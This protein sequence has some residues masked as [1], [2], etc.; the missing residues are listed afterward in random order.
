M[1]DKNINYVEKLI[2]A[3][4]SNLGIMSFYGFKEFY[5]LKDL[6]KDYNVLT[7]KSVEDKY[8]LDYQSQK[9]NLDIKELILHFNNYSA[10]KKM[11]F[12]IYETY[13]FSFYFASKINPLYEMLQYLEYYRNSVKLLKYSD[14]IT[15][16][17]FYQL[18]VKQFKKIRNSDD[19]GYVFYIDDNFDSLEGNLKS[20]IENLLNK[21]KFEKDVDVYNFLKE[22]S[23]LY[24]NANLSSIKKSESG[25][26]SITEKNE[27]KKI[28][29]EYKYINLSDDIKE[30][31]K[32][33]GIED[34]LN[35]DLTFLNKLQNKYT[36]F[37]DSINKDDSLCGLLKT[38]IYAASF[39]TK[40]S[41]NFYPNQRMQAITEVSPR[42]AIGDEHDQNKSFYGDSE[43]IKAFSAYY[44]FMNGKRNPL[45]EIIDNRL[46]NVMDDE[47]MKMHKYFYDNGIEKF[48]YDLIYDKTIAGNKSVYEL[49]GTVK[50][51]IEIIESPICVSTFQNGLLSQIK[52][53]VS[54][55]INTTAQS[56]EF[57]LTSV[58]RELFYV[59]FIPIGKIKIS[60]SDAYNYL[61]FFKMILE[62]SSDSNVEIE[63]VS[64]EQFVS[65][66]Y[67]LLGVREKD[68]EKI[69]F[70]S[71][72]YEMND[73]S[74]LNM[75]QDYLVKNKY[76]KPFTARNDL[77]LFYSLV[78]FG[79]YKQVYETGNIDFYY[80]FNYGDMPSIRKVLSNLNTKELFYVFSLYG[81]EFKDFDVDF[82]KYTSDETLNYN[83]KLRDITLAY[84]H[85]SLEFYK[86]YKNK[87]NG[88]TELNSFY[89]IFLQSK[90]KT[91]INEMVKI[92]NNV[93]IEN[94]R[95]ID[96]LVFKVNDI[97]DIDDFVM[98]ILPSLIELAH[99]F[100]INN[101]GLSHIIK[102]LDY[103]CY[104]ISDLLFRNMFIK[105]KFQLMELIKQFTD[106]MFE[107][108]DK[109]FNKTGDFVLK[110]DIGG[111]SVVKKLESI[112]DMLDNVTLASA[113]LQNCFRDP[114]FSLNDFYKNSIGDTDYDE[115]IINKYDKEGV[116]EDS[117]I[118]QSEKPDYNIPSDNITIN[119]YGNTEHN[120][121][122]NPLDKEIINKIIQTPSKNNTN[123]KIIYNNGEIYLETENKDRIKIIYNDD[124]KKNG[125]LKKTITDEITK[126]IINNNS[127]FELLI[128]IRDFIRNITN[129]EIVHIINKMSNI[130]KKLIIENGKLIPNYN[131]IKDLQQE[132]ENLTKELERA[133]NEN[134]MFISSDSISMQSDNYSQTENYSNQ[135][136]I[137]ITNNE[138]EL[139]EKKELLEEVENIVVKNN[140]PLTNYEIIQLLK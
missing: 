138:T 30:I 88:M 79:I 97:T 135:S 127:E 33:F 22:F 84:N 91:L 55:I 8:F 126:E 81:I 109:E 24:K 128:E 68:I 101:V 45:F 72:D 5:D 100:G 76:G 70:C 108:I 21:Y 23:Q 56:L 99:V 7:L 131:T 115:V 71:F 51:L 35:P 39:L 19:L 77:K 122:S 106:N 52:G 46:V 26:I 111:S 25:N 53:F 61:T 47:A 31:L 114:D 110:I 82:S 41:L 29:V 129:S 75:Y 117:K 80:N 50:E 18:F 38:V 74:S 103:V 123:K 64:R 134:N 93:T 87:D 16:F 119:E 20:Q 14:L 43:F 96:K 13:L 118:V 2:Q 1:N 133:K 116:L 17:D 6:N 78:K 34:L 73:K 69:G 120:I 36:S 9:N 59:Q 92:Y 121:P 86:T 60:L 10:I 37:C 12:D 15:G 44:A 67:K 58:M 3:F 28:P 62:K 98:R 90:Y 107:E 49:I 130:D 27:N 137:I 66:A 48:I 112:M 85:N 40:D 125:I 83:Y 42:W 105:I 140:S 102:I 11:N 89:E 139:Q 113:G 63:N 124:S 132:L 136:D 4:D 104:F 65:E 54:S 57:S 95:S 94:K 32:K